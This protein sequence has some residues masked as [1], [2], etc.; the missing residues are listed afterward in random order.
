MSDI[1]VPADYKPTE[2]EN[3]AEDMVTKV[4]GVD[5]KELAEQCQREYRTGFDFMN[6]KITEWLRRLKLYNN[7]R[8]NPEAVGDNTMFIV[9]QS[10][11][12]P[13]YDD[14]LAVEFGGFEEGDEHVAENLNYMAKFDHT[15]M[16]K[17]ILDY[18]WIWDTLFFGCGLVNFGNYDRDSHTPIPE[19][20]DPTTILRDPDAKSVNGNK[21]GTGRAMYLGRTL[22]KSIYD[23][24]ANGSYFNL[25]FLKHE[26]DQNS[27]LGQAQ[28]ARNDAQNRGDSIDTVQKSRPN[29]FE[30]TQWL[31]HYHGKKYIVELG[32]TRETV[33][34][35]TPLKKYFPVIDR[36][37]YPIAHDWDGVAVSDLVEDKQ[38]HRAVVLNLALRILT[39]S[40]YPRYAYDKNKIGDKGILDLA[41]NKAFPVDGSPRDVI[42][43]VETGKADGQLMTYML[44]TLDLLSQKSTA[45]PDMAQGAVSQKQRTL[46]ELQLVSSKVDT[47]YSLSAKVFGWSEKRFWQ[48]WYDQYKSN[49][50][51]T[52]D[53][54]LIR[55]VGAFGAKPRKLTRENIIMSTDPD[56]VVKSAY[57]SEA[58]RKQRQQELERVGGVIM[59]D[60]SAGRRYFFKKLLK[61][62]D[63]KKDEIDRF[64]PPTIDELQQ[65][66]ENEK[67]NK[68]IMVPVRASEN[69][70]IHLDIAKYASE[71]PAKRAH[72]AMHIEAKRLQRDRPELFPNM[73]QQ[74]DA[75]A[76]ATQQSGNALMNMVGGGKPQQPTPQ[77]VAMGEQ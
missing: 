59:Q 13:L 54:K 52:I 28:A 29:I 19:V 58:E 45:T 41:M 30:T 34:R 40:L 33:V 44:D 12:A 17:D 22:K 68:N 25:K 53:E 5:L 39:Y 51:S 66:E 69:H 31:T 23:M 20:W 49:L 18:E 14:Q 32:N 75:E 37:I 3:N 73:Q 76:T 35:L 60:P 36:K 9:F 11:F 43:A 63:Y 46:G 6:P 74:K 64:L 26:E 21:L 47:R 27:I 16:E 4:D 48:M 61:L 38:R 10:L 71:T 70:D 57:L 62:A 8:R 50:K 24:E 15:E 56:V 2:V 65:E 7:Q 42:S 1:F 77:Q 55:I 67:L 72:V